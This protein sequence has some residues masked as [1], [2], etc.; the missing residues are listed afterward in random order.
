[1]EAAR[2]LFAA[3]ADPNYATE[4][5]K[6][7]RNTLL[8]SAVNTPVPSLEIAKLLIEH[9]ADVRVEDDY[10]WT[11]LKIAERTVSQN[12]PEMQVIVDLIKSKL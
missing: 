4:E 3:G 10:G 9:G 2:L 7:D 6:S 5:D 8:T 11:A 1:V 12:H